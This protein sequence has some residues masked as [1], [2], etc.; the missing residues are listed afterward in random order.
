MP[1]TG[2][3]AEAG[4]WPSGFCQQE[5]ETEALGSQM[6]ISLLHDPMDSSP[7]RRK[8]VP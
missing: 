4:G 3:L 8:Y 7:P 1:C 6:V 5:S 2:G